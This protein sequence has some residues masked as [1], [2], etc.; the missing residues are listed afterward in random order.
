MKLSHGQLQPAEDDLI[1]EQF[2]DLSN[3][4]GEKHIFRELSCSD[5]WIRKTQSY[6]YVAKLA[7]KV[8]ISFATTYECETVFSTLFAIQTK[9]RNRL[10]ATND[11]RVVLAKIKLNIEELVEANQ[12]HPSY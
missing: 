7:L 2:V 4:G 5:F 9:S 3:D 10:E 6:P 1:Q 11:M 8:L 12:M